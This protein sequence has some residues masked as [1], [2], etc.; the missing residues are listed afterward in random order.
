MIRSKG[1]KGAIRIKQV[2]NHVRH[3]PKLFQNCNFV[4]YFLCYH[5]NSI[6]IMG[7]YAKWLIW[8][9]KNSK[10]KKFKNILG[11]GFNRKT[12]EFEQ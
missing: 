5:F 9:L 10:K 8:T 4:R 1:Y 3:P 11:F 2:K 7:S 12:F 6:L